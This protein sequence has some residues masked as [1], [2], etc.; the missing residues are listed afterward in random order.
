MELEEILRIILA[1]DA[2]L[3]AAFDTLDQLKDQLKADQA[4]VIQRYLLSSLADENGYLRP[5]ALSD[6]RLAAFQQDL[7]E[8]YTAQ[9]MDDYFTA[10]IVVFRNRMNQV[11]QLAGRLGLE[12]LLVEEI[13]ELDAVQAEI[14]R[15]TDAFTRAADGGDGN[16]GARQR[17]SD[18]FNT[19]RLTKD[20]PEFTLRSA[21]IKELTQSSNI[22]PNYANN[23]A[24]TSL[25]IIERQLRRLQSEE[26]GI[27]H[28]LYSGIFDNLIRD[29]C[30]E[31]LGQ[32]RLW[33]EWDAME[34]D[35]PEGFFNK[36]VSKVCGGVNCRHRLVPWNLDWSNGE[37][38]L[39]SRFVSVAG[40]A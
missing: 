8:F 31:Q 22:L 28:A 3:N 9:E 21:L 37:T 20:Q 30:D 38:D 32:V 39:R 14:D 27:Q 35:M 40:E 4:E 16:P 29:F 13:F 5:N 33:S 2:Q 24:S 10:N 17:I 11:N 6:A 15:L 25:G 1:D 34:N 18:A 19:Y 7:L 26:S 23:I 36:P 12:T